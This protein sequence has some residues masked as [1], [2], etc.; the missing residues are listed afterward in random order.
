LR[1]SVTYVAETEADEDALM[2]ETK[3]RLGDAGLIW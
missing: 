1:F 2:A 3:Q